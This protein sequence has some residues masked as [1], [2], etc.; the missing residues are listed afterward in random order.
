M[1]TTKAAFIPASLIIANGF[2]TVISNIT[3]VKSRIEASTVITYIDDNGRQLEIFY[4]I[5]DACANAQ[6]DA[7]EDCITIEQALYKGRR[8]NLRGRSEQFL[9]DWLYETVIAA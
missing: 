1:Q 3:R 6:T 8:V 5:I 2:D 7:S 9:L 4:R